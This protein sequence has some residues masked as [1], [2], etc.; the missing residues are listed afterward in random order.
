MHGFLTGKLNIRFLH[1]LAPSSTWDVGCLHPIA[2][3]AV[4]T[5]V[6]NDTVV[7]TP[8]PSWLGNDG[9]HRTR[10]FDGNV[11]APMYNVGAATRSDNGET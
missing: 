4:G 1:A 10:V 9:D 11:S 7:I 6:T 3:N 8:A 2:C 5:V